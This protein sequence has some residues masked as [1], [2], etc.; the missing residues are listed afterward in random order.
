MTVQQLFNRLRQYPD[1]TVDVIIENTKTKMFD[2]I[3]DV[4]VDTRNGNI[5]LV[6]KENKQ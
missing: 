6:K 3:K 1:W 2:D 5:I 4:T